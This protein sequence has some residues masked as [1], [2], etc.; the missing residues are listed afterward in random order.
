MRAQSSAPG[1]RKH[2]Q[3]RSFAGNR[4]C[5]AA[6]VAIFRRSMNRAPSSNPSSWLGVF[7]VILTACAVLG[8]GCDEFSARRKIQEGGKLYEKGNYAD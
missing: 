2:Q 3:G 4:C 1:R 7:A 8:T 6:N 5:G